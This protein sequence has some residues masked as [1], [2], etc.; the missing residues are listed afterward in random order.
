MLEEKGLKQWGY[1]N[2]VE[3]NQESDKE[4]GSSGKGDST[5]S[6]VSRLERVQEMYGKEKEMGIKGQDLLGGW[7]MFRLYP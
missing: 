7:W 6:K 5:P 1:L 3:I 2:L 4:K